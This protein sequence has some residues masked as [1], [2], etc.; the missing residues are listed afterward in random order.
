M[1][2]FSLNAK[3]RLN[4]LLKYSRPIGIDKRERAFVVVRK[5]THEYSP[6]TG[7]QLCEKMRERRRTSLKRRLKDRDH[8]QCSDEPI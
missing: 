8:K 1:L 6:K 5:T 2:E 7:E 4:A 3:A